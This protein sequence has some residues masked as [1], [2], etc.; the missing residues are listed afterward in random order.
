M[1]CASP[2]C[3]PEP[4]PEADCWQRG[5][6]LRQHADWEPG[7]TIEETGILWEYT[8]IAEVEGKVAIAYYQATGGNLRYAIR[9][10]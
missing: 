8:S 10:D 4:A 7:G 6:R 9:Y 1:S 3:F 2:R 5:D